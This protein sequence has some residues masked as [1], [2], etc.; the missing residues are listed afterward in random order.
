MKKTERLI[1]LDIFRGIIVALMIMVNQPGSWS[2]KYDQMSHAQWDGC[3]LTDMIFP[4]FL[5]IVGIACWFSFQKHQQKLSVDSIIKI[6]RR[7][8][9]IFLLGLMLNFFKQWIVSGEINLSTLRITGVLQRISF[10]F[11]IG[12][13]L[14]L[15]PVSYTHLTLPTILLV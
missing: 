12:A 11:G 1:T 9:L 3:T 5:F 14:C 10:C 15:S 13:I 4:F 8:V 2:Y 6:I 7:T